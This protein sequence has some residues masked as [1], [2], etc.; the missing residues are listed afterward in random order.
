MAKMNMFSTLS[1]SKLQTQWLLPHFNLMYLVK[2][3]ANAK[4]SCNSK[5]HVGSCLQETVFR[6]CPELSEL[7]V[8]L[9]RRLC[10]TVLALGH[11]MKCISVKKFGLEGLLNSTL[12]IF[13]W[14]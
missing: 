4:L 11:K 10:D 2:D 7:V 3:N 13:T 5:S 6:D 12:T 1:Y 9:C 14:S 8:L